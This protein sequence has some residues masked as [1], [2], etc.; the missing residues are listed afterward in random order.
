MVAYASPCPRARHALGACQ[1][2]PDG[3]AP[4]DKMFGGIAFMVRGHM[5][6]GITDEDLM[7]RVGP[8]AHGG[9]IT[10]PHARPMNFT[11]RPMDGFVYVDAARVQDDASLAAGLSPA[12]SAT[13]RRPP[14]QQKP[15]QLPCQD[16]RMPVIITSRL[17]RVGERGLEAL[18]RRRITPPSE[19]R[20]RPKRLERCRPRVRRVVPH[21]ARAF[22]DGDARYMVRRTSLAPAPWPT[23]TPTHPA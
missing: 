22:P 11:G 2:V 5:C 19:L 7:V 4:E 17:P 18:W 12:P 6:I 8:D 9:A 16:R 23:Y 15:C 14:Q 1:G 3:G 21:R 13:R 20:A 10:L